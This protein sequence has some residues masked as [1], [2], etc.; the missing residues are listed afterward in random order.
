M[1]VAATRYEAP[2]TGLSDAWS[3]LDDFLVSGTK[4]GQ[5]F[6]TANNLGDADYMA[7]FNGYRPSVVPS[8]CDKPGK[9]WSGR[10]GRRVVMGRDT[11]LVFSIREASGFTYEPVSALGQP[12]ADEDLLACREVLVL[13]QN[14]STMTLFEM[15]TAGMP[16]AVPS[17]EWLKTLAKE[18]SSVL[19]EL[20]F[21][22]LEGLS[23]EGLS[24]DNPCNY[25]S[26][27][28]IDWWLDRADFFLPD[29]M[30]NVRVVE[31]VEHLL[32]EPTQAEALGA[33]YFATI[34]ERNQTIESR[35][36]DAIKHFMA[37]L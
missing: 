27:D 11:G 33:R 37:M 20:S 35:R 4:A 10:G 23:T 8:L 25:K 1:I 7:F 19:G 6:I 5:L 3:G 21:A 16:V 28:Y 18:S 29:L 36:R 2:F 13:P 24:P 30:P 14:I 34:R 32:S 15:A 17:R 22:Q 31:S 9:T 26:P 12:Y